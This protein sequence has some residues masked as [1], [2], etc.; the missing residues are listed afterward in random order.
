MGEL[1]DGLHAL[2]R[3]IRTLPVQ[4]FSSELHWVPTTLVTL[5]T[6]P[7]STLHR[8]GIIVKKNPASKIELI[9]IRATYSLLSAILGISGEEFGE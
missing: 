1:R 7:L 3:T 9:R 2:S 5:K 6:E 4:R 8:H